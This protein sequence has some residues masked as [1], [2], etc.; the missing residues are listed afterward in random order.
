MYLCCKSYSVIYFLLDKP[1]RFSSKIITLF[2]LITYKKLQFLPIIHITSFALVPIPFITYS[3]F[4]KSVVHF[5][6]FGP[7]LFEYCPHLYFPISTPFWL[8]KFYVS[9]SHFYSVSENVDNYTLSDITKI[10]KRL[11]HCQGMKLNI[12]SARDKFSLH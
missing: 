6:Q 9:I 2:Y 3:K 12:I 10:A 1:I 8:L 11:P 5:S 4:L 7:H